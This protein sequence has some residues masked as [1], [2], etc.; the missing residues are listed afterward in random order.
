M[1]KCDFGGYFELIIISYIV[2]DIQL[3][4]VMLKTALFHSLPKDVGVNSRKIVLDEP[5]FDISSILD[6][7]MIIS[8]A[9]FSSF[10]SWYSIKYA[11]IILI[12][13][14]LESSYMK[15]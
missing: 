12:L 15:T 1:E 3:C 2:M 9:T 14:Q 8:F 10:M 5:D 6:F 7:V 4:S 13:F 11:P